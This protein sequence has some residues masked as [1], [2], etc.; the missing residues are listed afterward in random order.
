M[1][2]IWLYLVKQ[3][4]VAS[5]SPSNMYEAFSKL[6]NRGPENSHFVHLN[7]YNLWIGFHRLQIMDP[8]AKGDQPFVFETDEKIIYSICNGEIYNFKELKEKYNLAVKSGS[9]CE[10]FPELYNK[11]GTD[12]LIKELNGEFA[13]VI[14]DINKITGEVTLNVGRDHCGMRPLFITGNENEIVLTSELK[15]SPFL[16]L[17]NATPVQQFMPRNWLQIKNTDDKLYYDDFKYN[18]YVNFDAIKTEIYDIEEAKYKINRDLTQSVDERFI[19]DREIGCLLS[20]GVDSSLIASLSARKAEEKGITLHTFSIGMPGSTDKPYAEMVAKHIGSIHHHVE[21][22][23][24]EWLDAD[25]E[26]MQ[27]IETFE[28]TTK[29]ASFGQY[30]LC[31]Y[32]AKH[33]PNIKV[34]FCGDIS[35]EVASSYR[36]FLKAPSPQAM[37]DETVRLL[38]NIHYFDVLRCDRGVASNGLEVRVPFGSLNYI[39]TYL[40]IDPKLRMPHD[41]LEKWILREAF[42][43]GNYLP[44]EVLYR[45]KEAFSDGVS[46]KKRSFFIVIQERAEKEYTDAVFEEKRSKYKHCVPYSKETLYIREQFEKLFGPHEETAK[47]VP[48]FWVPQWSNGVMEPSARILDVYEQ[49]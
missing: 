9:D 46:S 48:Y 29:R 33:F 18:E 4:C 41:N 15:G 1:C 28:C 5:T 8:T 20:G 16:F 32:I 22:D 10:I 11:I 35:D 26:V 42:K 30:L 12:A 43:D 19:A 27:A 31:K 13:F 21:F 37:H 44:Y 2:G 34:V 40:S 49:K 39:K 6:E 3:G 17:E 23:E 14:I 38:N 47:V 36:Y 45:I 24:E 25:Y 7:K